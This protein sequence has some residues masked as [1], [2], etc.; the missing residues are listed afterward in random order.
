MAKKVMSAKGTFV[1]IEGLDEIRE[2]LKDIG[3]REGRNIMKNTVRAIALKI[4]GM[5]RRN[6]PKESGTMRKSITIRP[7]RAPPDAPVFEVWAGSG[8]GK[9]YDA[10]YWR[11]VEYGTGPGKNGEPARPA[12]P[13]IG[14]AA[15]AIKPELPSILRKEFGKKWE[16]ALARKRKKVSKIPGE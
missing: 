2:Q 6:A 10:F 14:P 4:A 16:E 3:V 5:A 7:R 13:F 15:E 9:K 1:T 11:F 12:R 8:S